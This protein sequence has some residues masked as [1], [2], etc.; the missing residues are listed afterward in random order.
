[1]N[2]Y[3][4]QQLVASIVV[5]VVFL[6]LAFLMMGCAVAHVTVTDTGWS[7]FGASCFRPITV[8]RVQVGTNVPVIVEGYR[9]EVDGKAAGEV[10]GAAGK[11]IIGL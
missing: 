3:V 6:A 11:V 10:I 7:F 1:M 8:S 4:K 5:V 2:Q 9:G